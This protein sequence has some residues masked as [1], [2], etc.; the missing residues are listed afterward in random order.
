MLTKQ[1]LSEMRRVALEHNDS[2]EY[3]RIRKIESFQ[4]KGRI[5]Q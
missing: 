4:K 3:Q 1:K 5:K 2:K